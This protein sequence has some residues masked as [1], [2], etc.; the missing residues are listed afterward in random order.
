MKN[1]HTA[2]NP[3][4]IHAVRRTVGLSTII[5]CNGR[6]LSWDNVRWTLEEITCKAC[7]RKSA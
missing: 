7:L 6:A 5:D 4:T 2:T 3:R 1:V